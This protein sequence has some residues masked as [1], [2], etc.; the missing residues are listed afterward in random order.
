MFKTLSERIAAFVAEDFWKIE[1]AHEATDEAGSPMRCSF[2]WARGHLFDRLAV[3]VLYEACVRRGVASIVS[4][5]RRQTRKWR[6]SPLATVE[7][8]KDASRKLRIPSDKAMEIAEQLYQEGY[9]SYPRTETDKFKEGF[10]LRGLIQ[11]QTADGRWAAHANELLA[12]DLEAF[13]TSRAEHADEAAAR[14]RAEDEICE[15]VVQQCR[16]EWR[17]Q[18]EDGVKADTQAHHERLLA[19]ERKAHSEALTRASSCNARML[20]LREK[21]ASALDARE[22]VAAKKLGR[23]LGGRPAGIEMNG[24]TPSV[25]WT[26]PPSE[27]DAA[28]WLTQNL[29]L[30]VTLT[31]NRTRAPTP[32]LTVMYA[33]RR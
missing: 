12:A 8:Q 3:L 2:N 7:L 4:V 26:T 23:S 29:T 5:G 14:R 15:E 30:T 9:L 17:Q 11:A 19:S 32:T 10:D 16:G 21:C 33:R 28:R 25:T 24:G 1:L 18:V 22:Y 13:V 27:V 31:L 20:A 6:P